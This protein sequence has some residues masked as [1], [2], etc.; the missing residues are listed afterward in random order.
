MQLMSTEPRELDSA[1][2]ALRIGPIEPERTFALRQAVLR[3]HERIE[4]MVLLGSDHPDARVFAAV[5]LDSGEVVGTAAVAPEEAPD[6]LEAALPPL[7]PGRRW[8]LRSM[9]TREDLRG[10]GIGAEV[11]ALA[12]A[13]VVEAGGGLLWLQ[14]RTGALRFYERAGFVQVGEVFEVPGIGPHVLMWQEIRPAAERQ[15]RTGAAGTG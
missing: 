4:D 11:L 1:I 8:R 9:A 5:H 10:S 13:W 6:R 12:M 15:A 3:P 2:G 14:A 7:P